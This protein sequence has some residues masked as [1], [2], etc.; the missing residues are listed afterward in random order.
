VCFANTNPFICI[1]KSAKSR[2]KANKRAHAANPDSEG[3]AEKVPL[4]A[5]SID[6]PNGDGTAKG[7]AEAL[8]AREDLTRAM[9][10]KRRK[11]IKEA[12]FLKG[13]R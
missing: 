12:N 4:Y 3:L 1:A 7:A 8:G 11:D 2:R 9:R 10:G 13:M 6:L 5:Q